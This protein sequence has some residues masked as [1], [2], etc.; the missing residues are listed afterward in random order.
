M[1]TC[2]GSHLEPKSC[3]RPFQAPKAS[4]RLWPQFEIAGWRR[5][6]LGSRALL[7]NYRFPFGRAYS[8]AFLKAENMTP[9]QPV[10]CRIFPSCSSL[11][12]YAESFFTGWKMK[13]PVVACVW[14]E[15]QVTV[16]ILALMEAPSRILAQF[17]RLAVEPGKCIDLIS[18]PRGARICSKCCDW[19]KRKMTT[20]KKEKRLTFIIYQNTSNHKNLYVMERKPLHSQNKQDK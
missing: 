8:P 19:T 14:E 1:N 20:M 17:T 2:W 9:C 16:L 15:R 3:L 7:L 13:A 4:P 10:G 6:A 11:F 18:V 5:A 12:R